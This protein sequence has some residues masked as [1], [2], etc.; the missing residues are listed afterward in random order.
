MNHAASTDVRGMTETGSGVQAQWRPERTGRRR[1]SASSPLRAGVGAVQL[2]PRASG[3][4][5]QAWVA[6]GGSVRARWA[7]ACSGHTE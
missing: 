5:P 7:A 2:Q 6:A 4:P 3:P 1:R